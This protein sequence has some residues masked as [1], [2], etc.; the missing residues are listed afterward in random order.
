MQ[1]KPAAAAAA[2]WE[3][4]VRKGMVIRYCNVNNTATK[5]L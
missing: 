3:V 2:A 1:D 4:Q 5:L